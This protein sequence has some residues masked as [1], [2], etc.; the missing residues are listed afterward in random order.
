[1]AC[2][3][4]YPHTNI[5]RDRHVKDREITS[6][7]AGPA[8][9]VLE[10]D[11]MILKADG[12]AASLL[13]TTGRELQGSHLSSWLADPRGAGAVI[14]E[15]TSE[16]GY[17]AVTLMFKVNDGDAVEMTVS[18]LELPCE[19]GDRVRIIVAMQPAAP[20]R[21]LPIPPYAEPGQSGELADLLPDIVFEMDMSG[22]LTYV[23]QTA[24]EMTGY[25]R[26]DFERG[27]RALDIL[28]PEDRERAA[29]NIS[30]ILSGASSEPHEYTAV[31]KDGTQFPVMIHSVPA[32][33]NGEPV[34]L[35]GTMV[36]VTEQKRAQT[37]L[38][39]VDSAMASSI[40]GI[41]IADM[42]GRL[43]Y[44]NAAFLRLWGYQSDEKV[45]RRPVVEFWLV[46]DKAAEVLKAL[47]R[48]GGWIGE[49]VGKRK[50]GSV[51]DVETAATLVLDDSGSPIRMMASFIDITDR[52][53]SEQERQR[54]LIRREKLHG[55]LEMA[56][57]TCHEFNQPMQVISG[58]AELLLRDCEE[59]GLGTDELRR[60]KAASDRM[61]E[62][63]RK[64]QQITRY[65]TREYVGGATIIDIDKSSCLAAPEKP[66]E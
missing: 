47:E 26:E 27:L 37:D 10:Q 52:K 46:A 45:L 9:M 18:R 6:G 5:V 4:V 58:Y 17:P 57:A 43:T 21:A 30:S 39:I 66:E 36:D 12:R 28:V 60:I 8:I 59:S 48:D 2:G 13:G 7:G 49:L 64:L 55:A 50:D 56:G 14:R 44:V 29:T 1:M 25:T 24:Y 53:R 33:R 40:N 32:C 16:G 38:R 31:R 62:I 15:L 35:R 41:A 54:E 22:T 11:G 20:G 19:C 23:N 51:F 3:S 42:E 65:E 34:G 61:I 63:T